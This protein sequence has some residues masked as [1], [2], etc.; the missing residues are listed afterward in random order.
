MFVFFSGLFVLTLYFMSDSYLGLDQQYSLPLEVIDP[1][2]VT[3][4]NDDHF[5]NDNSAKWIPPI[6]GELLHSSEYW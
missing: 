6:E 2:T 4:Q 1:I 5:L 3:D